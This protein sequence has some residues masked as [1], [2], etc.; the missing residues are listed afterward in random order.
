MRSNVYGCRG[1]AASKGVHEE[2]GLILADLTPIVNMAFFSLA[3]ASLILV[4]SPLTRPSYSLHIL[5]RIKPLPVYG[6]YVR[7]SVWPRS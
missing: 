2:M 7:Q 5:L 4:S 1:E 6:L 3:G